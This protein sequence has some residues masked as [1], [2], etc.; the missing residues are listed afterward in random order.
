MKWWSWS[1]ESGRSSL[2][3]QF[4]DGAL[5][6][7]AVTARHVRTINAEPSVPPH[8]PVSVPAQ[9]H[10]RDEFDSF[11]GLALRRLR[12]LE[13]RSEVKSLVVVQQREHVVTLQ[14]FAALEKIELYHKSQSRNLRAQ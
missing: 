7:E 13:V 9:T 10:R 4:V 11:Y 6:T 14:L 12:R 1:G 5:E 8:A 2:P 3:M